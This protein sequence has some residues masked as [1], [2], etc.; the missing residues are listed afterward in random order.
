[1]P[2]LDKIRVDGQDYDIGNNIEE[3]LPVGT[4]VE[5][6]GQAQNIPDGWQEVE[7]DREV[8]STTERR[9]GTWID[10][11]PLYQKVI[12][13]LLPTTTTDFTV[14]QNDVDISDLNAETLFIVN[15][16]SQYFVT[17]LHLTQ[18]MPF[19]Y[20]TLADRLGYTCWVYDVSSAIRVG[21]NR[22]ALSGKDVYIIVKY[23]KTTDVGGGN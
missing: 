22:A 15:T 18:C 16:F 14:V 1:M 11:K 8:Y 21:N 12:K 9:I 5:F 13:T 6:N 19:N 3:T 10:G 2:Y 4:R 7:D 23:T 17:T 20:T